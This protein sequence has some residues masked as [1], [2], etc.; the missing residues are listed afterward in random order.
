[1]ARERDGL[2]ARIDRAI[3]PFDA[4]GLGDRTRRDWYPVLADTLSAAAPRLGASPAQI[5]R[6]LERSGFVRAFAAPPDA[7]F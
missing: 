1:M 7:R 2:I 5:D 3:A 6:L 4:A